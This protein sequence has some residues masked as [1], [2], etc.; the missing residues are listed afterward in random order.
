[1]RA[2]RSK[3]SGK[4]LLKEE[5]APSPGNLIRFPRFVSVVRAVEIK[6]LPRVYWRF[7]KIITDSLVF[8]RFQRPGFTTVGL[9]ESYGRFADFYQMPSLPRHCPIFQFPAKFH[10]KDIATYRFSLPERAPYAHSAHPDTLPFIATSPTRIGNFGGWRSFVISSGAKPGTPIPAT[11]PFFTSEHFSGGD[12]CESP[13]IQ[14]R[15][16]LRVPW[17]K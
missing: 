3:N 11:D 4:P 9:V 7:S 16:L 10:A 17:H 8:R 1:M 5:D 12:G 15:L 6:P 14:Q 2:Q 13:S